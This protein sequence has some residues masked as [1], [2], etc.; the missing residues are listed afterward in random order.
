MN[1][2]GD[3]YLTKADYLEI[4]RF[5]NER[6]I[7]VRASHIPSPFIMSNLKIVVF[8]PMESIKKFL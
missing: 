4:V 3:R 5:A 8:Y 6:G 7:T 1:D 2:G